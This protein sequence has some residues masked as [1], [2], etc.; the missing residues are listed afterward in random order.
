[1]FVVG[2][3]DFISPEFS[4][5]SPS[6]EIFFMNLV[7]SVSNSAN[8]ASIRSKNIVDRPLKELEESEKNYWK[9]IS[10]FGAA[11][12]IDIYG[13]SRIIRRRERSR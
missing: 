7:D 6:N 5:Q 12:L 13:V 2:D 1:M 3:S 10:I 4:R 9:F 11:I 8:L